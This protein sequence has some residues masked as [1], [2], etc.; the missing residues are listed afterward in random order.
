MDLKLNNCFIA[1]DDHDKAIAFYCDVLGLEIRNDVKYEGM[2]WVTVGSPLQPDVS[3]VL[4]PPAANPDLSPADREAMERLL[5]KGVLR[6]VNFTTE[7]CDALFT[8]VQESGAEVIQEPTDMPYGVRDCA[9]RD[10]AGNMLR[11][12]E[13]AA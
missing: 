10:P 6:G 11:F 8:R 1:V 9:F 12:M 5:A 2:R 3:I 4:E 7:N 13:R